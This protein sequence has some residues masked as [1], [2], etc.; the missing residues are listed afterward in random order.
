LWDRVVNLDSFFKG[1]ETD[2]MK[3]GNEELSL[4]DGGI[5]TYLDK[6]R[7]NI[8]TI[9]SSVGDSSI[10]LTT[11]NNFTALCFDGIDPIKVFLNGC[12]G[13]K[14]SH[15]C[16]FFKRV[17]NPNRGVNFLKLLNESIID[18]VM[19]DQATETGASLSGGAD[20]GESASLKS[21]VKVS[22]IHNDDSVVASKLKD[23]AAESLVDLGRDTLA[24][25]S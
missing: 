12:L 8:V 1:L 25:L 10:S 6:C 17:T 11:V 3:N 21:Q 18:G 2:K 7:K 16:S 5:S 15:Q 23:C 9:L 14:G 24:N 13:M 20:C 4:N 19:N 22:I